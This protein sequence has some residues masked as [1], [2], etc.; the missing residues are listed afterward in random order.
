MRT[1]SSGPI[2]DEVLTI[3][4]EHP[5]YEDHFESNFQDKISPYNQ[6]FEQP[7][8]EL[9]EFKWEQQMDPNKSSSE[10]I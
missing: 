2:Q 6:I 7:E 1:F 4:S 9:I 8:E 3:I 10:H 5:Y